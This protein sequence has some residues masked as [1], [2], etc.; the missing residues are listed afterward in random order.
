M[1]FRDTLDLNKLCNYEYSLLNRFCGRAVRFKFL[2]KN[3]V[4]VFNKL[5]RYK[6]KKRKYFEYILSY[7]YIHTQLAFYVNLHRAV[8]GPTATLTGRW[9]PDID[10]RRMLTGYF[11]GTSYKVAKQFI[12]SIWT[13]SSYWTATIF[14]CHQSLA[15][16]ESY[17][18]NVL[19][20]TLNMVDY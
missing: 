8:I 2:F 9:R 6:Q 5:A 15:L 19:F 13:L 1:V 10:L 16:I 4:I 3:Y 12:R 20:N 14:E 18:D 17:A 11:S 7:S